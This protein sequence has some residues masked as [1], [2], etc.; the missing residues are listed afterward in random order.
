[1]AS[2]DNTGVVYR[3]IEIAHAKGILSRKWYI[4]KKKIEWAASEGFYRQ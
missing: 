4:G 1:M 3:G 2:L